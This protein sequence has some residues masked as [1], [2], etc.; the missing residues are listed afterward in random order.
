[1]KLAPSILAADLANVA[2]ELASMEAAGCDSVHWDV[3]DGHFV[4][5]LTFGVPLIRAARPHTALPFDVHLMV[6]DPAPYIP[7]LYGLGVT[8]VSFQLET[9]HFAP[10][11][12]GLIRE[13]GMQPSVVLNPQTALGTLDEVLHL[14]DN[15]LLMSV[16]PGFAG[17]SFIESAYGKIERLAEL[18]EQRGLSFQ[19]QVD[20]GVN[21]DNL[22]RLASLGVDNVVAGK[23]YFTA[24]DRAGFARLVH[25]AR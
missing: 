9:T 1:M 13:H 24:P 25:A 21:A 19:I 16:D 14:L 15:V 7:Q 2:T 23:A 4:P 10:R 18:R 8:L 17:Q 6:T 5:N 22:A 12:F 3:M 11:L 20:G